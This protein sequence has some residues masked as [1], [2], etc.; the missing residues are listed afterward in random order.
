MRACQQS[1]E[2]RAATHQE[3][4]EV[5][6]LLQGGGDVIFSTQWPRFSIR[7]REKDE[8]RLVDWLP[9]VTRMKDLFCG[10]AL[11][12]YH[13]VIVPR[14]AISHNVTATSAKPQQRR[15]LFSTLSK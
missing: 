2:E 14:A 3:L 12:C 15:L 9:L 8:V 6:N 11:C 7:R 10:K 5:L 1:E 13:G 4:S